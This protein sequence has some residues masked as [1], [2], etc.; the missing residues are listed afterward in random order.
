M[1]MSYDKV[2]KVRPEN[3]YELRGSV[4]PFRV[5]FV[6]PNELHLKRLL[7]SELHGIVLGMH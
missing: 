7:Y 3:P 2:N 1:F 4:E 6:K 5:F